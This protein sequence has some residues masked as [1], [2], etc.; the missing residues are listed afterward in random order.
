MTHVRIA[1]AVLLV[2]LLMS[3]GS[4]WL[5]QAQCDRVLTV[6]EDVAAAAEAGDTAAAETLCD[7]AQAQW[8]AVQPLLMCTVS[9]DKLTSV[10]HTICRLKPLLT[11]DCEEF[12]AELVTVQQM[13]ENIAR[14]ETPYLTN[15]L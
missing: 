14:G 9:Q 5:A 3:A 1:V 15:I 8:D 7:T 4:V 2:L 13:L 11:E 12:K 10:D 6:L